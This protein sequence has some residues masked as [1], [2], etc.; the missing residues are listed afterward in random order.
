MAENGFVGVKKL[1]N[2]FDRFNLFGDPD[3]LLH[4]H[5]DLFSPDHEFNQ[6]LSDVLDL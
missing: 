3:V 4:S 5:L 1:K 2:R 6:V